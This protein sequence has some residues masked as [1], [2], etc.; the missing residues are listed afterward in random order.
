MVFAFFFEMLTL[1]QIKKAVFFCILIALFSSIVIYEFTTGYFG[2]DKVKITSKLTTETPFKFAGFVVLSILF[3]FN[4]RGSNKFVKLFGYIF[5][6]SQLVLFFNFYRISLIMSIFAFLYT[7]EKKTNGFIFGLLIFCLIYTIIGSSEFITAKLDRI[8]ILAITP[9]A[10]K[11]VLTNYK[12]IFSSALIILFISLGSYYFLSD[13]IPQIG[14]AYR[15]FKDTKVSKYDYD[16]YTWI[17]SQNITGK[18]F[19][20][21][22]GKTWSFCPLSALTK[23][24]TYYCGVGY[25]VVS[26]KDNIYEKSLFEEAIIYPERLLE[27]KDK[28]EY[29]FISSDDINEYAKF[30]L[31][32]ENNEYCEPIYYKKAFIAEI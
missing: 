20:V 27:I 32:C 18:T 19:W 28:I 9:I 21:S 15:D 6:L 30:I 23:D 31:W 16:A 24:K 5:I 2:D 11:R 25:S 17:N 7:K 22:N 13:I 14:L 8:F 12:N 29:I 26:Q 10:L 1:K 3:I 4:S